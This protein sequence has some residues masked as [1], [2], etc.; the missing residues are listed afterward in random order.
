MILKKIRHL[1]TLITII[2]ID[3]NVALKIIKQIL[4]II[5]F[6]N[7]LNLRLMRG[8]NY[9]QRFNLN[10]YYKLKKKYIILDT[11]FKLFS[12]NNNL[13]KSFAEN[14]LIALLTTKFFTNSKKFFTNIIFF[15]A[16][17]IKINLYL[18]QCSFD[19]Y[20]INLN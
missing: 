5:L 4:L 14:K 18:K 16:F 12:K 10:I 20:I 1:M 3:Y 2:Y 8:F 19:K 13:Q 15:I 6:I 9:L 7:K 11:I 17:I